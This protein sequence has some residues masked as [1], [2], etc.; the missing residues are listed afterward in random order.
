[1]GFPLEVIGVRNQKII[2]RIYI[3]YAKNM[4]LNIENDCL[5]GKLSKK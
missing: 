1:M 3:K 5:D 4:D 2:G